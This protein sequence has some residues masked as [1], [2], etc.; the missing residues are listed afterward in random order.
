MGRDTAP[1]LCM[2]EVRNAYKVL[3]GKHWGNRTFAYEK[4]LKYS[5]QI[6]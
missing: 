3:T 5:L 1:A 6:G 2:E 4:I